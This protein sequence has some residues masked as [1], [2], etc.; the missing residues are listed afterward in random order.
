MTDRGAA[1]SAPFSIGHLFESEYNGGEAA[2]KRQICR[3]LK[4][5]KY[6]AYT[7]LQNKIL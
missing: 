5:E 7:L 3:G 2:T 4:N 6:S 1:S